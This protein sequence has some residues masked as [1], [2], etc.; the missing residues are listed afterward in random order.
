MTCGCG[1]CA[2]VRRWCGLGPGVDDP[3][4]KMPEK[5][6]DAIT[7]VGLSARPDPTALSRSRRPR[8]PS[9]PFSLIIYRS[10]VRRARL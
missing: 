8:D 6:P 7:T 1:C 10:A 4:A 2:A 3:E 5:Q 9:M